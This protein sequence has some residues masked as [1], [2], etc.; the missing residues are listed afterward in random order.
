MYQMP[1]LPIRLSAPLTSQMAMAFSGVASSAGQPVSQP[2]LYVNK[3]SAE[4]GLDLTILGS[5]KLR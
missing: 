3:R 5:S 2:A 1:Y 4:G